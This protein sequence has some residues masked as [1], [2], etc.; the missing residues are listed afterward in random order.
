MA[1]PPIPDGSF[2]GAA[3]KALRAT[4]EASTAH[5][6]FREIRTIRSHLLRETGIKAKNRSASTPVVRASLPVAPCRLSNLNRMVFHSFADASVAFAPNTV[7]VENPSSVTKVAIVSAA[8]S[9]APTTRTHDAGREIGHRVFRARKR[10]AHS[11]RLHGARRVLRRLLAA[12]SCCQAG[13]ERC[14]SWRPTSTDSRRKT[15]TS[16]ASSTD[17]NAYRQSG[18][19]RLATGPSAQF[20][21]GYLLRQRGYLRSCHCGDFASDVRMRRL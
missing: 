6:A 11:D 13:C 7:R 10:W 14:R 9:W 15:V 1:S 21:A 4:R 12:L 2:A 5:A 8:L 18:I 16:H 3:T 20:S 17:A 19:L